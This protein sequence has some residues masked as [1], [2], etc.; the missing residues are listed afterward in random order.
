MLGVKLKY[1]RKK[2]RLKQSDLALILGVSRSQV[3]HYEQNVGYP[4][5]DVLNKICAYFNVPLDYFRD[6]QTVNE[7]IQALELTDNEFQKRAKLFFQGQPLTDEELKK[8]IDFIKF[9]RFSKG[10]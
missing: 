3:S 4:S 5:Y 6:G 7:L 10:E 1:L 2:A 8:M 9:M